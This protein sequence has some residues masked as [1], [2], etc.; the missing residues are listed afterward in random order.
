MGY[1]KELDIIR[2]NATR[3]AL[4]Q[5]WTELRNYRQQFR[6]LRSYASG[7]ELNVCKARAHGSAFE[8]YEAAAITRS[9]WEF[10][11]DWIEGWR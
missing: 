3:E 10:L 1:F 2:Q 9:Q 8:A 7:N 11:T 5:M 4:A 6:E